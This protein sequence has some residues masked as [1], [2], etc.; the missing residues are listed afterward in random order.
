M[1][2]ELAAQEAARASDEVRFRG[3]LHLRPLPEIHKHS[4]T[5]TRNTRP[6]TPATACSLSRCSS[7]F[8][9]ISWPITSSITGGDTRTPP[10]PLSTPP[11]AASA[12]SLSSALSCSHSAP[13]AARPRAQPIPAPPSS[14]AAPPT[15]P[16][17]PALH[18]FTSRAHRTTRARTHAR[19]QASKHPR[20][21]AS[22][23]ARRTRT[24]GEGAPRP[25]GSTCAA[26]T[27][28]PVRA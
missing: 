6:C 23:H 11:L 19:K 4:Q 5:R 10:L 26:P 20:S 2:S 3:V 21:C 18:L 16:R 28:G 25:K 24:S 13:A 17:P 1:N 14:T 9:A 8:P 22:T 15:P 27:R 7:S 12:M